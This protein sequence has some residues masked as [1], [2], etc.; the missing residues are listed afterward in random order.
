MLQLLI[1]YFEASF[2]ALSKY[3]LSWN[4]LL[5]IFIQAV[6][7]QVNIRIFYI[8]FRWFLIILS[9]EPRQA[10]FVQIADVWL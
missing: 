6:I 8:F 2:T 7:C 9:T 4:E 1:E 3:T 10:F 5:M